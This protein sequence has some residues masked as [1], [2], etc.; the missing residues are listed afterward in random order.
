MFLTILPK[1]PVDYA[2]KKPARN[3]AAMKILN[4]MLFAEKKLLEE[5][6]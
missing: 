2:M 3:Q 5:I 1:R 6:I 4:F